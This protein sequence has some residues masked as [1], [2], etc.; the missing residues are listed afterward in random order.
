MVLFFITED[1]YFWSHRKE[2]ALA[3]K[4]RGIPVGIGTRVSRLRNHIT[5]LGLAVVSMPFRRSLRTPFS[6]IAACV[7]MLWV[8]RTM[9]P[10]IVH[11]VAIKPILASFLSVLLFRD[12]HFVHALAG[13]GYAF[14]ADSK[15]ALLTRVIITPV[16]KFIFRRPNSFLLVQNDDDRS[17]VKRLFSISSEKLFVIPGSGVD[18]TWYRPGDHS[19]RKEGTPNLV[20]L[21]ARVLYEKGCL[22]FARAAAKV[23]LE[24]P[25]CRFAL[26]G[27]LDSDNPGGIAEEQV[28]HWVSTYGI[29]WWGHVEDIRDVYRA[30]DII[31]LPSYREGL[32][33]VLLEAASCAKPMIATN[34]AGCKEICVHKVTGLL[35]EPKSVDG[36]VR[37]MNT[38]LNDPLQRRT[39]GANARCLVKEKFSVEVI[40]NQTLNLY[41]KISELRLS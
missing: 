14:T 17:L 33:K 24:H 41:E 20:V 22:E 25:T 4:R 35:V 5:A 23:K 18:T 37:A 7:R 31:C 30:A 36:L 21:P 19:K 2:L 15:K 10:V 28:H 27:G 34:V 6:D 13:L 11:L 40:T 29:E 1:W 38:L 26:V 32:P 8:I 39:Y 16:L 3:L 9:N 12:T